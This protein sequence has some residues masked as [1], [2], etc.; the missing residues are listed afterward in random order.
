MTVSGRTVLIDIR[1]SDLTLKQ[2]MDKIAEY[3]E[4]PIYADCEIFVDG[5][6]YAI[7][8]EPKKGVRGRLL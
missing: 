7:V 2:M 1:T 4:D 3:K 5:D 8:A 6:L